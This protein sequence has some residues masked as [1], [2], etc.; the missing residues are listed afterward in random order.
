MRRVNIKFGLKLARS[1]LLFLDDVFD[2]MSKNV[3]KEIGKKFVDVLWTAYPRPDFYPRAPDTP[4]KY[5]QMGGEYIFSAMH[6]KGEAFEIAKEIS[7]G[8]DTNAYI[9]NY[10]HHKGGLSYEIKSDVTMIHEWIKYW[11]APTGKN[12]MKV[13]PVS[14]AVAEELI[15]DLDNVVKGSFKKAVKK[16]FYTANRKGFVRAFT[17]RYIY[18]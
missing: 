16:V 15:L 6:F 13:R 12:A 17:S 7:E 10:S 3:S 2:E 4:K 14:S 18:K 11:Q 1:N 5:R 9:Y 8:I